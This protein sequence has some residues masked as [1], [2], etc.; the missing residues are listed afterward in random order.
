MIIKK[1][2]KKPVVVEAVKVT[3]KNMWDVM[4]WIVNNTPDESPRSAYVD[5]S[6]FEPRLIIQTLEGS[7]EAN[8][9]EYVIKGVKGEFYPCKA[10]VFDMTYTEV[11]NNR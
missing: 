8:I 11:K 1:F 6:I 7:M 3:K 2:R 9:G 4:N 10:D 5:K